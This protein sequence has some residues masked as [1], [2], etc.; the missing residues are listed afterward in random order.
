[1]EVS[2]TRYSTLAEIHDMPETNSFRQSLSEMSRKHQCARSA[3]LPPRRVRFKFSATILN[4]RFDQ[5]STINDLYS[6]LTIS[7][8]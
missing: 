8:V 3:A 2:E 4:W 6:L 5:P 7:N 1:M